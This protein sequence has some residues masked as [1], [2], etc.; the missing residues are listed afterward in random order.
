MAVSVFLTLCAVLF[1]LWNYYRTQNIFNRIERMLDMAMEDSFSETGFDESRLSALEAKFAHYL[2][3]SATSARSVKCEKDKIKSLIADISHQ[4]KTPIANLLLYCELLQEEKLSETAKDYA[5]SLHGQTEKLRF[6]IESLVKLSRLEN[7]I[8][9]LSPREEKIQPMLQK[10]CNEYKAKAESKG[11]KLILIDSEC[12]AFYDSKWT[13]EAVGNL[14][15][16]A[17]KYTENGTIT[18]SVTSYEMFARIDIADTG[19]GVPEEEHPKIFSRFYRS[20]R[21]RDQEGVGIG[22]YLAREIVTSEGGY[23]KVMS[24]PEKGSVFSVFLQRQKE[25][26]QNC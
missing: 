26:L 10:V 11:L 6:L 16:N 17:I 14:L 21:S 20:E 2:S 1:V 19:V 7:G 23:I 25:I 9:V 12:S 5:E 3:A 22:L 13:A 8:L 4:T 24:Q 15:D 18:V